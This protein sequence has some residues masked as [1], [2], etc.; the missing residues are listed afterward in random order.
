MPL[1][2]LEFDDS[3]VSDP[4]AEKLSRAVRDIVS[5]ITGIADVFVYANSARIKI[6]V[7]PIEIFVEIS[8][9]KV[10]NLDTLFDQCK[11]RLSTWKK[12]SSFPHPINFTVIPIR[13]KFEVD[14]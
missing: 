10:S 4:D 7:A 9:Q 3:K 8:E 1:I 5:D 6:Q 13:W 12:E 11:D 14:I 2:R